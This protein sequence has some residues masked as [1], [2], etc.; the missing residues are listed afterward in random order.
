MIVYPI[1]V[2]SEE[3]AVTTISPVELLLVIVLSN[4]GIVPSAKTSSTVGKP[5]IG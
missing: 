2:K 4:V 1:R 5:Q 3:E